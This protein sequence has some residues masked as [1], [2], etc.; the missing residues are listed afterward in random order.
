MDKLEKLIEDIKSLE[1]ELIAEL[2]KKQDEYLYIIK[3]KKVRFDEE[4]RRY[5][6]TLTTKLRTYIAEASLLHIATAPIVWMCIFPALLLDLTVSVYHSICFRVYKIP[7]VRRGD[8]IVIDRHALSYLNIIEKLNCIYCGY[9]IGLIDYVQEIA[10]RTE[11]YWCPI[12]HARKLN[13]IHG[14][15]HKFVEYG[16]GAEYHESFQHIRKDFSDLKDD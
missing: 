6:R 4:T 3:G 11:Q 12:K 13:N 14:R 1:Q 10:A 2:Q 9:F 15:Y 16:A 7:L 8:Y 5:H